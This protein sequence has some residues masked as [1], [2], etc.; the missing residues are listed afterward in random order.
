MFDGRGVALPM[1]ITW[2]R[3]VVTRIVPIPVPSNRPALKKIKSSSSKGPEQDVDEIGPPGNAEPL[4][5]YQE[6]TA[7]E[8]EESQLD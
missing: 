2:R 4:L 8:E 6:D 3:S 5:V 7:V 1:L